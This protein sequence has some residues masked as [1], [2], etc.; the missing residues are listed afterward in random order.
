MRVKRR[1][2][3]C[4]GACLGVLWWMAAMS[5]ADSL[6]GPQPSVRLPSGPLVTAGSPEEASQREA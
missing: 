3:V 1:F 4:L 6:S 2:A 5:Q